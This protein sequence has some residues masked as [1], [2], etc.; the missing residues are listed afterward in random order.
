MRHSGGTMLLLIFS[1]VIIPV[2]TILLALQD[3][4]FESNLSVISSNPEHK[5]AFMFWTFMVVTFLYLVLTKVIENNHLRYTKLDRFFVVS[6]CVLLLM[7]ATT[8]YTPANDPLK[9][10]L[11][12]IF[13]LSSTFFLLLSFLGIILELYKQNPKQYKKHL[14]WI[15]FIALV[16][17]FLLVSIG[18][19]SGILEIIITISATLL[20]KSLLVQSENSLLV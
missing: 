14:L 8:P 1:Y 9:A 12:I 4:L 15:F 17:I 10:E 2:Y 11:H 6:C 13:A 16:S 18:V 19:V 3:N 20:A 7:T 5:D